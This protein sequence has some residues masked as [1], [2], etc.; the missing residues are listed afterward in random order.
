VEIGTNFQ[1]FYNTKDA[2][3]LNMF[4]PDAYF[5]M[6]KES[7]GESSMPTVDALSLM[8]NQGVVAVWLDLQNIN[9]EGD[10]FE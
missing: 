5:G 3:I 4:S 8:D 6:I 1:H 2:A 10:K 7:C 9:T